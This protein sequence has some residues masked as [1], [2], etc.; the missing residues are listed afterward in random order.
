MS[1]AQQVKALGLEARVRFTGQVPQTEVRRVL[2]EADIYVSA[3]SS[4]GASLSLLE[5]MACGLFPVVSAIPANQAWVEH[6]TTGLL[7]EPGD[8][9]QL[10]DG[11][12]RA[13]GDAALRA[14]A[15]VANR[16][17]VVREGSIAA[18]MERMERLLLDAA[19]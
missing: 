2:Q 13:L 5:A 4:D 10:A 9:R 1:A 11:L 6:G 15:S 18:N 14:S 3:S 8:D 19:G 16:A 17:R 12:R 7:F